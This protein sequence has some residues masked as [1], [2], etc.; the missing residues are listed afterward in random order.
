[1]FISPMV[2]TLFF[3]KKLFLKERF[4]L[5]GEVGSFRTCIENYHG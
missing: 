5:D 1:M 3:Y 2:W 4:S